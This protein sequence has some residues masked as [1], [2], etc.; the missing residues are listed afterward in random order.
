VPSAAISNLGWGNRH[1]AAEVKVQL[2]DHEDYQFNKKVDSNKWS[3]A[4]E[5]FKLDIADTVVE[6]R[7][8]GSFEFRH[9]GEVKV[10][11]QVTSE[12]PMW[13][14]GRGKIEVDGGF[15][16]GAVLVWIFR[17]KD[18]VARQNAVRE[19]HRSWQRVPAGGR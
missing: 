17:D 16:A 11:L 1:G 10:R 2:P 7:D 15:M 19:H 9:D 14:P 5:R 18:A 13:R 12:V 8:D 3:Y 4:E 6:G